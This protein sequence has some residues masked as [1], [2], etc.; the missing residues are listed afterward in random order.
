MK[1]AILRTDLLNDKN[2]YEYSYLSVG[3]CLLHFQCCTYCAKYGQKLIVECYCILQNIEH[4]NT[5]KKGINI[6]THA[7]D[8]QCVLYT[9]A[10]LIYCIQLTK[11]LLLTIKMNA[12]CLSFLSARRNISTCL[13]HCQRELGAPVRHHIEKNAM[14]AEH[15]LH[16]DLCCFQGRW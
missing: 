5:I 1:K 6:S 15:H 2:Y 14:K 13:P 8:I 16:Q 11:L 10:K 12:S 9:Q 3:L 7:V 4:I